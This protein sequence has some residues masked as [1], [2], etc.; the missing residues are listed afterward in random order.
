MTRKKNNRRNS[1]NPMGF[2][3]NGTARNKF[4]QP[5]FEL[6]QELGCLEACSLLTKADWETVYFLRIH[7][8]QPQP[9]EE[10]C[11]S[12]EELIDL[13]GGFHFIYH[14]Q[15]FSFPGSAQKFTIHKLLAIDAFLRFL[16]TTKNGERHK[17]LEAAFAPIITAMNDYGDPIYRIHQH[18]RVLLFLNIQVDEPHI[19]FHTSIDLRQANVTG[20]YLSVKIKKH[21]PRYGSVVLNGNRRPVFQLGYP[22]LNGDVTWL[23]LQTSWMKHHYKGSK[24][25][26]PI[27]MQA[28]A[29]HR[30]EE[31][32]DIFAYSENMTHL[33]FAF[34]K[35]EDFIIYRN[36]LLFTYRVNGIKIGYFVGQ[37]VGNRLLIR[38]FLF[39][40]HH[41]TPEGNELERLSGLAKQDISYWQI[42]RLSTFLNT[43]FDAYPT[44]Y[45]LFEQ[46]GLTPLFELK[47]IEGLKKCDVHLNVDSLVEFILKG[48]QTVDEPY[49]DEE[50]DPDYV[51]EEECHVT[52]H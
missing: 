21:K 3:K 52:T 26:L 16:T 18:M 45:N 28:H 14:K 36:K 13:A 27:C 11:I 33:V 39:L 24:T 35:Q 37:V 46:V 5:F 42:D 4:L 44:L 47:K 51:P 6:C 7:L 48:Q 49:F 50:W 25:H 43:D 40:T 15:T 31:R 12:K 17:E 2:L 1:S 23:F 29:L 41:N 38:T 9:H 20:I 32:S 10:S 19:S 34:L 22:Q 30:L 8:S